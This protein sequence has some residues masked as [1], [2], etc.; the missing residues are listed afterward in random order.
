MRKVLATLQCML[1]YLSMAIPSASGA[2]WTEY[3]ITT[4]PANQSDPDIEGNTVVWEDQRHSN[5]D[6]YA[7]DITD[8]N[9]PLEFSVATHDNSEFNPA[10]G[11]NFVFYTRRKYCSVHTAS[12]EYGVY[13]YNLSTHSTSEIT[14]PCPLSSSGGTGGKVGGADESTAVWERGNSVIGYDVSTDSIFTIPGSGQDPGMPDVSGNIVVW[15]DY[16]NDNADIY[17][18]D[19]SVWHKLSVTTN[20]E[21]RNHPAINDNIVIWADYRN[22][23]YDIYGADVTDPCNPAE[24]IICVNEFRQEYPAIS[25]NIIVWQDNRN[26]NWDIY[27]YDLSTETEFQI[28]DNR[29]DQRRPA[30]SGHTI[31][32]EDL[33]HGQSDIYATILYGPQVPKCLSSLQGD[34]NNDC[35]VD[36]SDFALMV[37][38]W[39]ECNLDPPEACWE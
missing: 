11:G 15:Q 6:I 17:G 1:L 27:G 20:P 31:V 5:T 35:K 9:N 19:M 18:F 23:N 28:T 33:R 16:R 3:R 26:G 29:S 34:L 12:V 36:F 14:P 22:G 10:L 4:S 32:W 37:N 7:A 38:N 30:I 25:G 21:R 39:L 8:P 24:L 13:S 2:L